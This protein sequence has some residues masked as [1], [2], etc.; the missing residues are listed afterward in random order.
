M[1]YVLV[2]A[3]FTIREGMIDRFLAAATDVIEKVK[4]E[5]PDNVLYEWFISDDQ[6]K[7]F[8]VE[9]FKNSAALLFHL[10]VAPGWLDP[11]VGR[12]TDGAIYGSASKGA[13]IM[14]K[15]DYENS[16]L[17]RR[18]VYP[19]ELKKATE[20][21]DGIAV[22]SEAGLTQFGVNR[23]V[24]QPGSATTL[25]HWHENEDEFVIVIQG[26]V[27]LIDD[28]GETVMGPGDCAGFR[29]GDPNGHH[30][31]NRSDQ[32]AVLYEIGTRLPDETAHYSDVDMRWRKT[33]G[34]GRFIRPDGSV[35][36]D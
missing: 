35:V 3:E 18:R 13:S 6:K 21:Y 2:H 34:R 36:E 16:S 8:V 12:L 28:D 9:K 15:I 22:G 25:R 19:G 10:G 24:L 32:I 4:A 11:E 7:C 31:V 33:D 27:L 17:T 5:E 26:T 30:I 14:P 29:A 20:G 23:A 1:D